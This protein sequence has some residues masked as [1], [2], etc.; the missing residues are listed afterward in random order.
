MKEIDLN[1]DL[2]EG[3]VDPAIELALLDSVTSANIA[4]G[5]HAGDA[6]TIQRLSL[7]CNARG[8]GI[9][10]HPSYPDREGFGRDSLG[11]GAS[12]IEETVSSQLRAFVAAIKDVRGARLAH[13]KPHGALYHD[14]MKNVEIAD[15]IARAA[16]AVAPGAM[17]MGQAGATGLGR[18]LQSGAR[19]VREAFADRRY[20][21][22]GTL[23][24][25]KLEGA[26]LKSADD[27]A[28]QAVLIAT[29]GRAFAS[30][31]STVWIDAESICLH[32]DTPG[33]DQFASAVRR[34]LL[35]AG[36]RVC[37]LG[38]A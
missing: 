29:E 25:R 20:E 5:A 23:R 11:M 2:G 14:A 21:A 38:T 27:A 28:Q 16:K 9:G 32:S 8:I 15:A 37:R 6:A 33:A 36:V 7:A 22:D 30:D 13:V 4:C 24:S 19:V 1:C 10:A 34:A 31:G 18:W 3:P 17:L 26:L 35:E 12:E